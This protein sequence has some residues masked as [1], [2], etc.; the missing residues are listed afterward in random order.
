MIST[1]RRVCV[2]LTSIARTDAHEFAAHAESLGVRLA[3]NDRPT[4]CRLTATE[5]E[6]HIEDTI[7]YIL[8]LYT[9]NTHQTTNDGRQS[10]GFVPSLIPS[11][12]F[13]FE[14][15]HRLFQHCADLLDYAQCQS[16]TPMSSTGART[17]MHYI[18]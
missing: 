14:F 5:A 1:Y 8:Q 17:R 12:A 6:A 10:Q 7:T 3:K 18:G 13:F 2:Q 16:R 9:P 4:V 15:F 11:L